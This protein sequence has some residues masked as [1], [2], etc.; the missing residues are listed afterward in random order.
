MPARIFRTAA[1][2]GSRSE[3]AAGSC[4]SASHGF[5]RCRVAEIAQDR[6]AE[7]IRALGVGHHAP[8][9]LCSICFPPRQ[10]RGI[11]AAP[12]AG[13]GSSSRPCRSGTRASARP[14]S[15]TA[16]WRSRGGRH[17]R[18]GRSPGN[19]LRPI[20]EC[21][22]GS[23]AST[24]GRSMPMPNA[25]VAQTT[26][27]RA[28]GECVLHAC[29]FRVGQ[30]GVIR[31]P[32]PRRPSSAS[33]PP[34]RRPAR[35]RIH[36]RAL[37]PTSAGSRSCFSVSPETGQHA[38]IDVRTVEAGDER[39][40]AATARA[41]PT[42]SS[43]TSGVAVAVNAS[44][45]RTPR[46][47]HRS[48]GTRLRR[49]R[50]AA[51][52]RAGSRGPTPTRSALR[53]RR[54]APSAPSRSSRLKR[55]RRESFGR[56]V[57]QAQ[58]PAPDASTT[59]SPCVRREHRVQRGRPDTAPIQLI[60]LIF[61][62]RDER[63]DDEREPGSTTAGSWN[64]SDLPA[65]VGITASTSCPSIALLNDALTRGG[66]RRAKT[67]A[68]TSRRPLGM[69]RLLVRVE[70]LQVTDRLWCKVQ[71]RARAENRLRVEYGS[72]FLR[73]SAANQMHLARV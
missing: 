38:Q 46:A 69:T 3:R 48:G 32:P 40:A 60:D 39:A 25:L 16:A 62:Q 59:A 1:P 63:R 11:D 10:L 49:H 20:Q 7:A 41:A 54:S 67:A 72:H 14:R 73:S 45:R 66:S 8:Q 30:P 43:R 37:R 53:R 44:D 57:E 70:R 5:A 61:H 56:D 2:S 52:S 47:G 17:G 50:A 12:P 55:V 35:G 6:R 65:P 64:Q 4:C 33:P 13:S 58:P 21:P 26:R 9:L 22:Y 15:S 28:S 18:L 29:A 51:D 19:T 23:R 31:A 68:A 27:Q 42:M 71:A 24:S 36:Q 34:P